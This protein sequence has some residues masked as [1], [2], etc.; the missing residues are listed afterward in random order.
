V[1]E[2]KQIFLNDQEEIPG[3]TLSTEL[4]ELPDWFPAPEHTPLP[5]TC[6]ECESEVSVTEVVTPWS[7][8]SQDRYCLDCW[9]TVQDEI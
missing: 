3:W 8:E 6:D 4:S 7:G 2:L 1:R 9:P 5:V